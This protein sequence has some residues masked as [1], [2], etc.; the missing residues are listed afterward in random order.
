MSPS[1][2]PKSLYEVKVTLL[3]TR[4]AIW[5]RIRVRDDAT[6]GQL[7]GVI[8]AA[9][10]WTNSHLHQF[11]IGEEVFADPQFDL[12]YADGDEFA[13]ALSMALAKRGARF[14]YEYDF[15]DSWEHAVELER[16]LPA[17]PGAARAEVVGGAR[18]C[19]PT[20]WVAPAGTSTCWKFSPI[21]STRS[22][23]TSRRGWPR[24]A[25]ST[26]NTILALA[27]L[28][29]LR[30][31]TWRPPTG[32]SRGSP[33]ASGGSLPRRTRC[34]PSRLAVR[35]GAVDRWRSTG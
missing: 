28:S 1:K 33:R 9:M 17:L 7:H 31:S 34:L 25:R 11:R 35:T 30:R 22:T 20:T 26:R 4:P 13:I 3:D 10:G 27:S 18:A 19:P 5:R 32:P 15:G 6:L 14:I 2:P 23:R 12:D 16:I 8:Q 21:P 24:C 29:T